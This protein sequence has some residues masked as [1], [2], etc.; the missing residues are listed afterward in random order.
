MKLPRYLPNKVGSHARATALSEHKWL[1]AIDA[2]SI[3]HRRLRTTRL[4]A[5]SV[6]ELFREL[7]F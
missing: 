2:D 7:E 6:L 5:S 3:E 1:V 4:D